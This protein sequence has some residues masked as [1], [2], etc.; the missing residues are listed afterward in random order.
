MMILVTDLW[1]CPG[2]P[3][4]A[5]FCPRAIGHW[6]TAGN[7]Y[8]RDIKLFLINLNGF[9]CLTTRISP[10]IGLKCSRPIRQLYFECLISREALVRLSS[11]F[12]TKSNSVF[13][14]NLNGFKCPNSRISPFMGL[15]CSRPMKLLDFVCLI[16]RE[17]LD[18][19]HSYFNTKLNSVKRVQRI[20]GFRSQTSAVGQTLWARNALHQ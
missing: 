13:L 5:Q 2:L 15:K 20:R 4:H 11:F 18:R 3:K 8:E 10:L 19:F 17:P 14:I 7:G 6:D 16:S 1:G 12:D 9:E